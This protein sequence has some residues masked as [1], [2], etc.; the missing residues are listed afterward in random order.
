[1]RRQYWG[2]ETGEAYSNEALIREQYQGIRPAPGYPACPDHSEKETLFGLL[3]QGFDPEIQLTESMAML[4]VASVS[5]FY[6][7]HPRS[8][9]FGLGQI[10]RDQLQHYT[11]A[12]GMNEREAE[13]WLR[14][15]LKD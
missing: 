10:D 14:P 13:K 1:M 4:P 5:G 3:R 8:R 2:Y 11:Q 6:F 9:Y 12:K 7:A 15:V